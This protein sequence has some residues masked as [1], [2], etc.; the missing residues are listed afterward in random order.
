M[1]TKERVGKV[2]KKAV[3][4]VPGVG[5]YQDK[6]SLRESDK[7]LRDHILSLIHI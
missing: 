3:R 4:I 1:G 5:S 7:K 2:L 6:E